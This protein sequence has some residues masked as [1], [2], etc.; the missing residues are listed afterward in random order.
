[1]ILL[2]S[3]VWGSGEQYGF[4]LYFSLSLSLDC[5]NKI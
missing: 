1:M 2:L 4:L 3:I 5:E